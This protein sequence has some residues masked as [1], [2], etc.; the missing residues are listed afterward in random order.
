M[1][2]DY[3]DYF[4]FGAG[5]EG[6]SGGEFSSHLYSMFKRKWRSVCILDLSREKNICCKTGRR[7]FIGV[8]KTPGDL[9]VG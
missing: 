2:H 1:N 9:T 4:A 8:K 6:G 3:C 5:G 7:K